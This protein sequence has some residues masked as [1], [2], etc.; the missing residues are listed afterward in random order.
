MQRFHAAG[1]NNVCN[2]TKYTL[3]NKKYCHHPMMT[4]PT[5]NSFYTPTLL[6]NHNRFHLHIQKRQCEARSIPRS[7]GPRSQP[8]RCQTQKYHATANIDPSRDI[9]RAFGNNVSVET[10]LRGLTL[11]R[12]QCDHRIRDTLIRNNTPP[13][14]DADNIAHRRPG[15]VPI[16]HEMPTY[17]EGNKNCTVATAAGTRCIPSYE[18]FI[19]CKANACNPLSSQDIRVDDDRVAQWKCADS[20]PVPSIQW[21]ATYPF[22]LEYVGVPHGPCLPAMPKC[23]H[24]FDNN[25]RRKLATTNS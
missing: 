10:Q 23:E 1:A 8:T 2:A 5:T 6:C 14:T 12:T 11:P 3:P 17:G 22:M 4:T 15:R 25:T 20:K 21:N 7:I 16:Q 9:G 18:T 19:G 24:L 13:R